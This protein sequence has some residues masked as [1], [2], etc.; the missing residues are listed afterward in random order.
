M[1]VIDEKRRFAGACAGDERG[2]NVGVEPP[3]LGGTALEAARPAVPGVE[4]AVREQL[5]VAAVGE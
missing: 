5:D 4:V 2:G 3:S 1:L